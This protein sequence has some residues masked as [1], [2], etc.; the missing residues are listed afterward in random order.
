MTNKGTP[1]YSFPGAREIEW[2]ESLTQH[3]EPHAIDIN[4]NG[5]NN[6]PRPPSD[7]DRHQMRAVF[8]G[9][10]SKGEI[11]MMVTL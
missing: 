7:H 3:A 2:E 6:T 11:C 8:P 5:P 4:V 10:A 9:G 1:L